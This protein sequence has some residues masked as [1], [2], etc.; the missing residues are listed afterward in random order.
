MKGT[1]ELN[2][3]VTTEP[4]IEN[5]EIELKGSMKVA[6][7][8]FLKLKGLD[9]S[10]VP[11]INSIGNGNLSVEIFKDGK[12]VFDGYHVANPFSKTGEDIFDGVKEAVGHWI[13]SQKEPMEDTQDI[14]ED[15]KKQLEKVRDY[16]ASE[17]KKVA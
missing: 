8:E 7:M 14:R 16:K 13:E 15:M 4:V 3:E 5:P 2:V 6:I 1:P 17:E 11:V 9:S 12:S 10:F